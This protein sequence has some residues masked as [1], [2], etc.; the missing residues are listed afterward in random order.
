MAISTR[1]NELATEASATATQATITISHISDL[2]AQLQGDITHEQRQRIINE[3]R[4]MR[5]ALMTLEY[6][7]LDDYYNHGDAC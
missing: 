1:F 6:E 3:L 5:R 4:E 2:S 7:L